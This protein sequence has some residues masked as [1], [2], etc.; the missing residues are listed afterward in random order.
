MIIREIISD[1]MDYAAS[2]R[3]FIIDYFFLAYV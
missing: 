2:I 1:K 3:L